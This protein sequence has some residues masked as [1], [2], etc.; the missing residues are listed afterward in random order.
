MLI[1][2]VTDF[3]LVYALKLTLC[4]IWSNIARHHGLKGTCWTLNQE[5]PDS[6][7]GRE[8]EKFFNL[9]FLRRLDIGLSLSQSVFCIRNGPLISWSDITGSTTMCAS[10]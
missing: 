1:V 5:N 8:E 6:N 7:P 3:N 2:N 9:D 4:S 10:Q